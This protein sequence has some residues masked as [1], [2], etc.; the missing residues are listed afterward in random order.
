MG[1]LAKKKGQRQ[2]QD[3]RMAPGS[4]GL[5][6]RVPRVR[7]DRNCET[8]TCSRAHHRPHFQEGQPEPTRV[9]LQVCNDATSAPS[10]WAYCRSLLGKLRIFTRLSQHLGSLGQQREYASGKA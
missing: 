8:Q 5:R 9:A 6:I 10:P 2:A 4:L 7:G 1:S 3:W